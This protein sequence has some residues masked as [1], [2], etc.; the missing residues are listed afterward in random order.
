MSTCQTP[1]PA[2]GA[3]GKSPREGHHAD[4]REKLGAGPWRG[5]PWDPGFAGIFYLNGKWCHTR[6]ASRKGERGIGKTL[7]FEPGKEAAQS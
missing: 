4:P 3:R 5:Q 2:I 6:E 1:K 7:H